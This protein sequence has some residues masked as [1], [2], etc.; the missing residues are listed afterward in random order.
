M[1]HRKSQPKQ[2]TIPVKLTPARK[3]LFTLITIATPVLFLIG[4]ELG[5]R[6]FHYGGDTKLFVST[7]NKDSQYLG[8]NLNIGK[9]Y[10]PGGSFNPTPRK[11]LFLKVKPP[12]GYRIFVLGGSTTAGFP[13][14][15]NITFSRILNRRLADTFPE[16]RIEVINT[17]MT[18][19]NSYSLLD[20]MDEIIA[21]KP[22][23]ILIYAGHNEFYGALGVGSVESLGQIYGI[24][25]TY[26]RLQRFKVFCLVRDGIGSLRRLFGFK[27]KVNYTDDPLATIMARIVRDQEITLDSP[28]YE[29]GKRQFRHNLQRIFKKA[30]R[31]KIPVVISELVSNTRDQAPFVSMASAKFPSASS[32]YAKAHTLEQEG[33]YDLARKAYYLAKDLDALRFRATEDFNQIIHELADKYTIPVVPMEK[34][35][36]E[37]SPHDMIGNNLICDH[38]HPNIDGYFLMA[39]AFY[40]TL[41]HEE[42]ITTDWPENT[43]KPASYYRH[44]WGY[45]LLDSTY[46][47]LV[48]TQLKG[49]WPFQTF[50]PNRVLFQISPVTVEDSLALEIVKTGK[51]TL[52]MAHDK[53]A[54][55]YIIKGEYRRALAEY[56]ALIY[57]VPYLDLFYE[58]AIKLLVATGQYE[59]GAAILSEALKYNQSFLIYKWLGQFKLALNDPQLGIAYL[60]QALKLGELDEHLLY[61]LARAY[62]NTS[63]SQKGDRLAAK[64]KANF[65][66]SPFI[67]IL[68]DLN[69]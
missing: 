56:L 35:F 10:F 41:C 69:N 6:L 5:L 26:L 64:L 31:A 15:N 4:L 50:G 21:Q 53:L 33:N 9:R 7:P 63:Q 30:K 14:G 16:R 68:E 23:A 60:E 12:N 37:N 13:Y 22:D 27:S 66:G 51:L 36:E 58:P 43:L 34:Y 44:N 20:F 38:L 18:A 67:K 24:T 19:I 62:Y 29:R 42:F 32:M 61:N 17:A 54:S 11:D 55:Y 48:I 39:D 25:L 28:V 59:L 40:N 2:K 3:R 65:P 8:I 1:N 46:A 45:T 52:E 49:G 47:A 57:E